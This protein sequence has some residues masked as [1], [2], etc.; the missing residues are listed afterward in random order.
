MADDPTIRQTLQQL[1]QI[2]NGVSPDGRGTPS[3]ADRLEAGRRYLEL[4]EKADAEERR[5]VE[6]DREFSLRQ[7]QQSHEQ[8]M[9]IARLQLE[10]ERILIQKAEVVVRAL[11]AAAKNPELLQPLVDDLSQK[12]LPAPTP[13]ALTDRSKT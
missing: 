11:E 6:V 13:L 2:I 12:L 10:V 9:E 3:M 8:E 5:R 1:Q 7:G 4:K